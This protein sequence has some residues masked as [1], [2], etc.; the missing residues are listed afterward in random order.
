MENKI[1]KSLAINN[2]QK[3]NNNQN[4]KIQKL[5]KNQKKLCQKRNS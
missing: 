3:I 2:Q 1:K 5:S 4:K